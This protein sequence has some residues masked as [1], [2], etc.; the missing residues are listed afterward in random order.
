MRVFVTGGT[1]FIGSHVVKELKNKENALLLLSRQTKNAFSPLGTANVDI[2]QGDL[3]DIEGWG[4]EV[5]RFNPQAAI[6]MAWESLPNYDAE[7][8]IRNLNYGLNLITMLAEVGCK[9]VICAGSCW[10]YGQQSGE[11]SEEAGL[12]PFN[13]FSAAKNS[14]HWLGRQIAEEH[15]MRFIWTRLF[16]VY[17]PG[18]REA[19]LIPYIINCVRQGMRP[20]IKNPLAKNDFI[21][22]GDVAG[23]MAAIAEKPDK[24]GVYNIGSGRS[25]SVHQIVKIVCDK[26]NFSYEG[27]V[28]DNPTNNSAVDF[29]ADISNI[30]R[31]TGWGPKTSIDEG[32]QEVIKHILG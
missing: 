25:T 14:L 29:W 30:K 23:A 18:Q 7:T 17:G 24:D 21:Y 31:D 19:S 20:E 32:I 27:S 28:L 5:K 3:S 8:S 22:V 16:Y 2:L 9:S 13:A 11:V 10:E 6:H 1:G 4:N 15:D 12:K 26:L